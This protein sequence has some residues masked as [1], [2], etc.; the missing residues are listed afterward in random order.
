[1]GIWSFFFGSKHPQPPRLLPEPT[2]SAA[3]RADHLG[4]AAAAEK[5]GK[6]AIAE[7]RYNDAWRHFHEQ[8]EHY[9][10]HARRYGMTAQQTVALDG[11]VHDDLANIRRLERKHDDAL[12]HLLYCVSSS[13]RPTKAQSKKIFSYFS[14]CEFKRVNAD[15]LSSYLA[16]SREK[17]DFLAAKA[18]VAAWR[19]RE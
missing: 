16:N 1:M 17:S 3:D 2:L 7:A 9:L 12:A 19:A 11:S 4:R 5:K 14:R 13:P 15:E 6:R 8:K 18:C 10:R